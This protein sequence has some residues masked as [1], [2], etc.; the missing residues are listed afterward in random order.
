MLYKLCRFLARSDLFFYLLL[1]LMVLLIMGTMAQE[2]HGLYYAQQNYFS[3]YYFLLFNIIPLPGTYTVLFLMFISLLCKLILDTWTIKKLGTL[4][5]HISGLLLLLGGFLTAHF[6]TEGYIELEPNQPVNYINSYNNL[7][8]YI[9]DKN[10]NNNIIINNNQIKNN[11]IIQFNN[12]NLKILEICKHCELIK[13]NTSSNNYI[14]TQY[15][16]KY[17]SKP[18]DNQEL[19][20]IIKLEIFDNNKSNKKIIYLKKNESKIYYI[21][22]TS[23][24]KISKNYLNNIS[25]NLRSERTTLPFSLKLSSF[26]PTM[27]PGTNIAKTYQSEVSLLEDNKSIFYGIISM[28]NPLRYKGYTF[29]QSSYLTDQETNSNYISILA[30]VY[31][32]GQNFP[33]I[34]SIILC[35]GILI[36]LIQR[37]PKLKK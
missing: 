2:Q 8:L 15:Y 11:N 17:L 32:L 23:E 34:A 22:K 4:V 24:D 20:T 7:E 16:L 29:Y 35:L 33:Y 31:N 10:I 12:L 37:L 5:T 13:Y 30:A 27:H 36:H 14:N 19:K 21:N 26:K 28:N 1:W 18:K 3:V 25:I 6:S 9:S